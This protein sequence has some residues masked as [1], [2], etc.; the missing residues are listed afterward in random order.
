MD[1]IYKS[2]TLDKL[3]NKNDFKKYDMAK[4]K[5]KPDFI[6]IIILIISFSL[7]IPAVLVHPL[8]YA[9]TIL[10]I[11]IAYY[12]YKRTISKRRRKYAIY[13]EKQLKKD[14]KEVG[15]LSLNEIYPVFLYVNDDSEEFKIIYQDDVKLLCTYNDFKNYA[16]YYN[17]LEHKTKKKLPDVPIPTVKKYIMEINFKD[18]SKLTI[19]FDNR[20]PKFVIN[21][22]WFYQQFTNSQMI[23]AL[24]KI[25]DQII[26]RR[27]K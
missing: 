3:N 7:I 9:G 21:N 10:G 17:D 13:L 14:A 1:N 18:D 2:F 25:I 16:I 12:V 4:P 20:N 24:A 15:M 23:N 22:R 19:T 6:S 5:N 11:L 8:F 26:K 27:N